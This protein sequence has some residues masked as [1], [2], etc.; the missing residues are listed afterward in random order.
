[1][2]DRP[3]ENPPIPTPKP[4]HTLRNALLILAVIIVAG[5][6]YNFASASVRRANSCRAQSAGYI[7][8]VNTLYDR[9][10]DT[11]LV[12]NEEP[13]STVGASIEKLKDLRRE[14]AGFVHPDCANDMHSQMFLHMSYLIQAYEA[15][16]DNQSSPVV[17]ELLD[18]ATAHLESFTETLKNMP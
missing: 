4:S 5:L 2:S 14:F 18:Q 11:M 17:S 7:D 12:A 15:F 3:P 16:E 6:V 1:M 13:R 10:Y 9:W 8:Q